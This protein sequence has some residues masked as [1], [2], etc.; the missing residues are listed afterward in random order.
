MDAM[1]KTVG[2]V[3]DALSEAGH[4]TNAESE[5]AKRNVAG[6]A[7]TPGKKLGWLSMKATKSSWA[8]RK[9]GFTQSGYRKWADESQRRRTETSS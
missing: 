5:H 6:D 4:K 2:D 9:N 1:E 3:S 8:A 7:M